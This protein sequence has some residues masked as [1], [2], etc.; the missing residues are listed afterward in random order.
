[1]SLNIHNVTNRSALQRLEGE[2]QHEANNLRAELDQH[3]RRLRAYE[4]LEEEIDGAVMRTAG[5]YGAQSC[6]TPS[7]ALV[8]SAEVAAQK[9]LQ[10]VKGIP[11]N[12]ERRVKQAVYLAQRLLEAERQ[13]DLLQTELKQARADLATAKQQTQVAAEN[14]T[15]AAQP[16]AYLVNKLRDEESAKTTFIAKCRALEEEVAHCKRGE[17]NARRESEQLKARLQSLLQQ[18][19]ELETVKV[20]LAQLSA[21]EAQDGD[22]SDSE[23]SY[24]S[25]AEQGH[26]QEQARSH[27]QQQSAQDRFSA[28]E[29]KRS[30]PTHSPVSSNH[31]AHSN[32]SA[33]GSGSSP[34]TP[35]K[36][37]RNL[38]ATAAALG[39]TP[40]QLEAMTSPP[41]HGNN[42]GA[43]G[44]PGNKNVTICS[45]TK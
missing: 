15:R 3:T 26:E 37:G 38:Q 29:E 27:R 43:G 21:M 35:E 4:T 8:E 23:D 20:M 7:S 25:D 10:S 9:L 1:M 44:N 32:H 24:E 42:A 34:T 2:S 31:S 18:R 11:T 45:P 36:Q 39:L 17:L 16:T 30:S 12:P 28:R 22:S 14:L 33:Q 40:E 13:R 41:K 19:G 6:D 5:L